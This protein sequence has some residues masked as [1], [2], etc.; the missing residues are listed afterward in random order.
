[1][2][3]GKSKNQVFHLIGK[4]GILW[5]RAVE[6]LHWLND[7]EQDREDSRAT[8]ARCQ[9]LICFNISGV[10][11][12]CTYLLLST[13]F[14]NRSIRSYAG[15]YASSN[16]LSECGIRGAAA[17]GG[18]PT[19]ATLVCVRLLCSCLVCTFGEADGD[20]DEGE[21]G[22]GFVRDSCACE[23]GE[24]ATGEF[25][26]L[27]VAFDGRRDGELDSIKDAGLASQLD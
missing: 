24:V 1:M 17:C 23:V 19:G 26:W 16:S 10:S 12:T 14:R 20:E 3:P 9:G 6:C 7:Q 11:P 8:V 25:T 2:E 4:G 18:F 5:Y 22:V 21:I 13:S 15:A 27:C